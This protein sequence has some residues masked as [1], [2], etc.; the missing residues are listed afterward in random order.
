MT[1]SREQFDRLL[2]DIER[3]A[4]ARGWAD[5][6]AALQAKA[7]ELPTVEP[8]NVNRVVAVADAS[9]APT[10]A[11]TIVRS[12]I[13]AKPGL[14]GAEIVRVASSQGTPILERT[15]RSCLHRLKGKDI[16]QRESRWYPKRSTPRLPF[17]INGEA[18]NL[19][20]H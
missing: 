17:E 2:T 10:K 7:A 9:S 11:I 12:I 19:P 4:Y 14:K 20:P 13:F 15:V 16:W 3:E 18:S 1:N 8:T 6:I 5:A